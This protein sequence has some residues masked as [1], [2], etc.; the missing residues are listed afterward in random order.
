M[1]SRNLF[2]LLAKKVGS[3]G[4]KRMEEGEGKKV[5]GEQGI[6]LRRFPR[7]VLPLISYFRAP[8]G[9]KQEKK[10]REKKKKEKGEAPPSSSCCSL[11]P[12]SLGGGIGKKKKKESQKEKKKKDTTS[13]GYDRKRTR[14]RGEETKGSIEPWEETGL[15]GKKSRDPGTFFFVCDYLARKFTRKGKTKRE[16]AGWCPLIFLCILPFSWGNWTV[17]KKGGMKEGER[18]KTK[19]RCDLILP[20]DVIEKKRRKGGKKKEEKLSSLLIDVLWQGSRKSTSVPRLH[21]G[22]RKSKT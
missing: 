1:V 22:D 8:K 14:K 3:T 2:Y 5:K 15:R 21:A 13:K 11:C 16:K 7:K 9:K 4:K 18:E 12:C 19:F 20:L 6:V 17:Q 10:R